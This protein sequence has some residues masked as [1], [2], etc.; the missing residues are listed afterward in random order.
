MFTE[1]QRQNPFKAANRYY[2][3]EMPYAFDETYVLEMEVLKG[4]MID[5]APKSTRVK[6]NEDEG[7][8]EY[9]IAAKGSAIQLRSRTML[10]K[11]T[12]T[13]EDYTT[14]R[15]FFAMIVKKHSE[16]IVLKKI[17]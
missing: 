3:V 14:L 15:D 4:Y 7:M 5:E 11:A 2:P 17:K 10:K 12:F 9:L 16:Q 8:F 6:F 1:A 13:A